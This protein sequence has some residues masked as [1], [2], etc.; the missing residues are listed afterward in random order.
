MFQPKLTLEF[1]ELCLGCF[2]P[3]HIH[4][5]QLK[6]NVAAG[7]TYSGRT[8]IFTCLFFSFSNPL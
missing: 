4:K 8:N 5:Y 6:E 7:L 1:F 2:R 3:R